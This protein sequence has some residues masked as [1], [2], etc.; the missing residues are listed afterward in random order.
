MA[1]I[2]AP[3]DTFALFTRPISDDSTIQYWVL[4]T[5]VAF[6]NEDGGAYIV[7]GLNRAGVVARLDDVLARNDFTLAGVWEQDKGGKEAAMEWAE[8]HIKTLYEDALPFER[9]DPRRDG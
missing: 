3:P 2:P 8:R 5:V 7:G 6:D 4:E 9:D 1:L